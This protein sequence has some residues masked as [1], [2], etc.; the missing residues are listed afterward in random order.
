MVRSC[1][2]VSDRRRVSGN[3]NVAERHRIAIGDSPIDLHGWKPEFGG[4]LLARIVTSLE[5]G[6]VG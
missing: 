1:N 5:Q 3:H 4:L 6:P 2:L